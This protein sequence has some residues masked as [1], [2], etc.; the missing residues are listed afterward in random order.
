VNWTLITG[1]FHGNLHD[2]ATQINNLH[3]AEFVIALD[4][5]AGCNMTVV[6]FRVPELMIPKVRTAL[7]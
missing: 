5:S 7:R 3:L 4:Y 1:N 2:T 6:V